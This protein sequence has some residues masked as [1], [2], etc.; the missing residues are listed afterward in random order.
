MLSSV[1]VTLP[2]GS[3]VLDALAASGISY[4]GSSNYISA[5]GGLWE[6]QCGAGSGWLY[7]V[8]GEFPSKG[9]G[10]YVLQDGDSIAWRYTCNMG[11]DL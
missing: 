8:N 7:S 4:S 11:R 9:C 6:K 1:S 5:I 10:Q 3:T 2:Q